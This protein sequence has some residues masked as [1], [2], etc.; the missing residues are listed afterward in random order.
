MV[1]LLGLCHQS[2]G[3]LAYCLSKC[4][5]C[6][7]ASVPLLD[8]SRSSYPAR[9]GNFVFR[10]GKARRLLQILASDWRDIRQTRHG[11]RIPRDKC[12]V[13]VRVEQR[14]LRIGIRRR[15][16]LLALARV[17]AKAGPASSGRREAGHERVHELGEE[18]TRTDA[19]TLRTLFRPPRGLGTD[20]G[21][22]ASLAGSAGAGGKP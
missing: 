3:G 14:G 12:S 5:G 18:P 10:S 1:V 13:Q 19:S 20:R 9:A 2:R 7:F 4:Q 22:A 21:S 15:V 11:I 8:V 16:E 17:L 6:D